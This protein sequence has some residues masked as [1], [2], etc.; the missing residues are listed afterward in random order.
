MS[1]TIDR[2]SAARNVLIVGLGNPD[3]GDDGIGAMVAKALAGRLPSDIALLARSGDVMSLI[4]DWAGYSALICVDA[5]APMGAPG[6]I[7]RIDLTRD[8]LPAETLFTS[9]HAFGLAD[10][11]RLAR[12][13]QLAPQEIVVYAVEG[14]NF[15]VGAPMSPE[16]AAAIG[17][18]ADLVVGE[19]GRLSNGRPSRLPPR[20]P[21]PPPRW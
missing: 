11:V 15:E 3:R 2:R 18:V 16:V 21:A 17:E 10:A 8:E 7:H 1:G 13:L 19:V 14:G 20:P 5:A 12:T 6:R 9:T 4:E